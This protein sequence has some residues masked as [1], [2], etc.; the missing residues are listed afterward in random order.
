MVGMHKRNHRSS[1]LT[2]VALVA[3]LTAPLGAQERAILSKEV[4]VG[5][6]EAALGLEFQDGER[7]SI[8]LRDGMV[9]L[10]DEIVPGGDYEPGGEL[11]AAFRG[12]LGRAVSLDDGPLAEALVGWAPPEGLS[13][14]QAE[15]GRRIDEALES[16]LESPAPEER[17]DAAGPRVQVEG[18]DESRFLSAVLGRADRLVFL[19]E[20][21]AGLDDIRIHVDEDVEIAEGETVDASLLLVDSDA[22]I[23]GVV[24]R[25]VVAVDGTVELLESGEIRG[26]VR[27]AEGE[28][29]RSGGRLLGEVRQLRDEGGTAVL[30]RERVEELTELRERIRGEVRDEIRRELRREYRD[31][32][33]DF[34]FGSGI[35]AP[36]R[37]LFRA[38]GG[39]LETLVAVFILGVVGVGIVAFA[40][41]NL[42]TVAEAARR[43]PGRAAMVGTAG[44]FLLLPVYVLGMAALA[45]SIVG[46]PALLAWIPLFPLAALAAAVFG[47]V[48]VARNVGEWLA[49]S[50]YRYTDWIRRSN[51]VYTIFGGLLG[52]SALFLAGEALHVVPFSG[53]FRGLLGFAGVVV[54]LAAVTVGLGAVLLTRGGRRP[55]PQPM[56]P[57]EAWRQAVDPEL[58]PEL[59]RDAAKASASRT[60]DPSGSGAASAHGAGD[61]ESGTSGT[62]STHED[63]GWRAPGTAREEEHHDDDAGA[64]DEGTDP[65][66]PDRAD[67]APRGGGDP[68][69]GGHA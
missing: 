69:G 32:G 60:A 54:V 53:F 5:R 26:D 7:L 14:E 57:D 49:D 29:V 41:H 67:D 47:Y 20:A 21:L 6:D 50:G 52:L 11:D 35:L 13:R 62:T 1:V 36:F 38:V 42:D 31:A 17:A 66:A 23:G 48:A 61:F 33:S 28:L 65:S 3:V 30:D 59:S 39:I 22:R 16:A 40:P 43:E 56:D 64:A 4:A 37:G 24:T 25:D 8:A 58:E 44:A 34:D 12:L 2:G 55:E 10:D 27:L 68:R 18:S 15:L 51:A 45:I 46:I 9:L 19:E 63:P